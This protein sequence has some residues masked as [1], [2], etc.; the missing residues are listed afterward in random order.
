MI[1][2]SSSPSARSSLLS[3]ISRSLIAASISRMVQVRSRSLASVDSVRAAVMLSRMECL[4]CYTAARGR[5]EGDYTS[6]FPRATGRT[7]H[8]IL[9]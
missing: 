4:Y 1:P 8:N 3:A 9:I 5:R 2:A 7:L 6:N